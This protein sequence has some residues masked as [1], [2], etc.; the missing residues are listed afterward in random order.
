MIYSVDKKIKIK[1]KPLLTSVN[2]LIDNFNVPQDIKRAAKSIALQMHE[3]RLFV[4]ERKSYRIFALV[5][6]LA[7][8]YSRK[9]KLL[10]S[11]M[12][13]KIQSET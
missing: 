8:K 12:L 6:F 4:R 1:T 13:D 5:M 10:N 11:F 3:R 7:L 2:D 9:H